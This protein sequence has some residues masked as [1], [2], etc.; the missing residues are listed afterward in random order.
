MMFLTQGPPCENDYCR[1]D[2]GTLFDR[3]AGSP[4]TER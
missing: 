4:T 2:V 3:E 1:I